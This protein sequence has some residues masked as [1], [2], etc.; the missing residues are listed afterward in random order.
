M[1]RPILH[2]FEMFSVGFGLLC[3]PA[4]V[5]FA[6]NADHIWLV[7]ALYNVAVGLDYLMKIRARR[8]SQR[9][10][11]IEADLIEH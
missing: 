3:I 9:R 11:A 5:Y 6:L 8:A 1:K 4:A 10:Q 7:V 2:R